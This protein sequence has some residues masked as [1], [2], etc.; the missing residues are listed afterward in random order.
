MGI[1]SRLFGK[2]EAEQSFKEIEAELIKLQKKINAE[3]IVI[4]GTGGRLKGLPLIYSAS[5]ENELKRFSARIY[6][7]LN[8]INNLS[9]KRQFR[10]FIINYEDSILFF[11]KILANIGYFAIFQNK[12]D[13]LSLKQWVYKKEQTLKELFHE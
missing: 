3:M 9:D 2:K 6:E 5:D 12:D 4:F 1:L 11:K 7:L 10:D 13:L 8:P